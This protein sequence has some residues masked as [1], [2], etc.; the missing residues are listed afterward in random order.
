MSFDPISYKRAKSG[1]SWS[2]VKNRLETE[3]SKNKQYD[4]DTD[5]I[6]EQADYTT[7]AGNADTVD[8]QHASDFANAVHTHP[9]ADL[10][11]HDL[12]NHESLGLRKITFDTEANKS[13][14]GAT[15]ELFIA[16]DTNIIYRG[17]GTGWQEIGRYVGGTP[18]FQS[19]KGVANG[20]APLDANAQVPVANLPDDVKTGGYAG[21][22]FNTI[23]HNTSGKYVLVFAYT[24]GT[25]STAHISGS[26]GTSSPPT[27]AVAECATQTNYPYAAI[28]FIVPPGYYYKVTRS[29]SG[30]TIK[31]IEV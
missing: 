21:K 5:G 19:N 12:T 27:T 2:D 18:E 1:L 3:G 4:T 17:T 15:T 13:A 20:Y 22:S 14:S 10:T 8:G 23:Y 11:D 7:S 25:G 26:I 9:V 31:V 28:S 29:G 24:A 30:G 6:V 16:T